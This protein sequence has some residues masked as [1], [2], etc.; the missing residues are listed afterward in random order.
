MQVTSRS[1]PRRG[2]LSCYNKWDINLI[3]NIRQQP[4]RC[5]FISATERLP[6]YKQKQ[7]IPV[8]V[9]TEVKGSRREAYHIAGVQL[10][11]VDRYILFR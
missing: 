8:S 10:L 4:D 7:P 5:F 1:E 9:S 6:W 11:P 2:L 3:E